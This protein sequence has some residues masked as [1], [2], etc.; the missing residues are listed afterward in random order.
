MYAKCAVD[1]SVDDA[2][3]VFDLMVDHNVVS[4]TAIITGYVQSGG[5]DKEAVELFC[6]MIEGHVSPNHFTFSSVLKACANLSDP[7]WESKFTRML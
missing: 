2:R 1:G 5:R 4:W 7:V 6:E 3:K